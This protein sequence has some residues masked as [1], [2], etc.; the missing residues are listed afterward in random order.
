MKVSPSEKEA[1]DTEKKENPGLSGEALPDGANPT[2]P[3]GSQRKPHDGANLVK[4]RRSQVT[5]ARARI[6]ASPSRP[7]RTTLGQGPSDAVGTCDQIPDPE[8]AF[9]GPRLEQRDLE[10]EE[11]K[12]GGPKI[13]GM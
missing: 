5:I 6:K 2:A 10:T 7:Q 1:G 3:D 11:E 8:H 9:A 4:N 13:G 12:P